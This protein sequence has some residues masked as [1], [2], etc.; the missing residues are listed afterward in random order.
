MSELLDAELQAHSGLEVLERSNQGMICRE[1]IAFLNKVSPAA[2]PAELS[3]LAPNVSTELVVD[4]KR[5]IGT[6]LVLHRPRRKSVPTVTPDEMQAAL[7][8]HV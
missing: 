2:W 7:G 8:L 4:N 1:R 3:Q 6:I 5:E